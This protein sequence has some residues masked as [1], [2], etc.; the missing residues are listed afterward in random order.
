M[1]KE[2][3]VL[4]PDID[5]DEET[6]VDRKGRRITEDRAQQIAADTL[7]KVGRGRPSLAGRRGRSPQ[8]TFRLSPELRA[9]AERRAER[10][11]KRVS[12]VAREALEEYLAS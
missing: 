4:G 10:E 7:V 12:D 2:R 5:L 6:V 3:Y 9:A 1:S 11:G 8:V